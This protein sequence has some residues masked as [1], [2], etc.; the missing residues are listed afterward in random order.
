[1]NAADPMAE[2]VRHEFIPAAVQGAPGSCGCRDGARYVAKAH[3]FH[4]LAAVKPLADSR[5]REVMAAAADEILDAVHVLAATLADLPDPYA[6]MAKAAFAFELKARDRF[7][8]N[9]TIGATVGYQ[10]TCDHPTCHTHIQATTLAGSRTVA[11][12]RGWSVGIGDPSVGRVTDLC[13][14]HRVPQAMEEAA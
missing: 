12:A 13:P 2:L 7:G 4:V 9:T 6:S 14:E 8:A 10:L 1:M 11:A 3:R 5:E